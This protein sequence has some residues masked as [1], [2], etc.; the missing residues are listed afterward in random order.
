MMVERV[1]RNENLINT[2]EG[3]IQDQKKQRESRINRKYQLYARI[4]FNYISNH[5]KYKWTKLAL[6]KRDSNW[7]GKSAIYST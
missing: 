1:D 6:K 5:H 4:K 3:K 2:K 7:E